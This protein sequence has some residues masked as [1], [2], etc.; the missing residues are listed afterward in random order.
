[1]TCTTLSDSQARPSTWRA[2]PH[3]Q[4]ATAAQFFN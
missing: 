4:L 3:Q 1:M 2:A